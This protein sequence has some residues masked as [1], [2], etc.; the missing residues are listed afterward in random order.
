MLICTYHLP[1]EFCIINKF[2]D[3]KIFLMLSLL[4][5]T[6]TFHIFGKLIFWKIFSEQCQNCSCRLYLPVSRNKNILKI[7]KNVA[8]SISLLCSTCLW[9]FI[10]H[11]RKSGVGFSQASK[12]LKNVIDKFFEILTIKP[13]MLKSKSAETQITQTTKKDSLTLSSSYLV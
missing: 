3:G 12:H 13:W 8:Y 10:F 9:H 7:R 11:Y 2:A 5:S 1:L 4:Q 6:H